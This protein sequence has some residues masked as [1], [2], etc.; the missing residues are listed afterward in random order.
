MYYERIFKSLETNAL[1]SNH[2]WAKVSAAIVEKGFIYGRGTNRNKTHPFQVKYARNK[3]SIFLHAEISAIKDAMRFLTL[4]DLSRADLY[5]CRVKNIGGKYVYGLAK[6]CEGCM[7]AIV[8]F[9]INDVYF[10]TDEGT[11]EKL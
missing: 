4:D 9:G 3:D 6:P 8:E 7:R 5:I 11:I 10:T 2:S 1:E